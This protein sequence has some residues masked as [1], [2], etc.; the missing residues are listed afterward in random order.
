MSRI[1][2]LTTSAPLMSTPESRAPSGGLGEWYRGAGGV[3]L[4]LAWWP[5]PGK[6]RGTVFISPGR[7]EPI[8]KYYEMIADFL[9]RDYAVVA[10]DW[11]GQGLSARLLPDRLKGHA[12]SIEE[13]TDDFDSLLNSFEDRAPRP[14]IAVGHSMGAA[15][16][17]ASLQRG[18]GRIDAALLTS[19][20]L[21]LRTGKHSLWTV[22]LRTNWMV[23]QGHSSDYVPDIFDDPFNQSFE[24]NALTHDEV[25]Y[26]RWQEQLFACPHLAIG[27]PTWGWLEFALQLG[28]GLLRDKLK[29]LKKIKI[30]V[31][32]ICGT[33]D[34]LIAPKATRLFAKKMGNARYLELAGAQHELMIETDEYRGQV[35]SAFDEL[36]ESLSAQ[37]ITPAE[38]SP[39]LSEVESL[40]G[41]AFLGEIDV[42]EVGLE[43]EPEPVS[44]EPISDARV[45]APRRA[46]P[47]T[48]RLKDASAPVE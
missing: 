13:Y 21:R 27:S 40:T 5:C 1:A 29:N 35:L 30:P 45:K 18:E 10:H 22:R 36:A 37:K 2:A 7:A 34:S 11:R 19:P 33:K 46:T 9:A 41:E 8:E 28:E 4:R 23:K 3:R 38:G 20:M 39:V 14:W 31:T 6:A 32:I 26:Q 43:P 12:R 47:K 16:N 17:L 44:P 25:R 42:T 15:L 24:R 48:R